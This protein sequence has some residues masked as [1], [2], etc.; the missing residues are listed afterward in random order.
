MF[1]GVLRPEKLL[2]WLKK[3]IKKQNGNEHKQH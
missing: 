3:G 2:I 1:K